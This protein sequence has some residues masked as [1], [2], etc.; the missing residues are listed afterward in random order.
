M[1][2]LLSV[3]FSDRARTARSQQESRR[4]LQAAV[5][6]IVAGLKFTDELFLITAKSFR[7]PG[8]VTTVLQSYFHPALENFEIQLGQSPSSNVL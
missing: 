5:E 7:N 2:I 4:N 8:F 3:V 6:V 1:V